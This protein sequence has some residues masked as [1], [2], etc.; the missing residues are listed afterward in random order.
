MPTVPAIC[1]RPLIFRPSNRTLHPAIRTLNTIGIDVFSR[2]SKSVL[3]LSCSIKAAKHDYTQ[4]WLSLCPNT[5]GSTPS[6][7]PMRLQGPAGQRD[8]TPERPSAAVQCSR[9]TVPSS[10]VAGI[11]TLGE[12]HDALHGGR[13]LWCGQL[14]RPHRVTRHDS[15]QAA[16]FL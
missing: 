14:C 1:R 8:H 10:G 5:P 11:R 12:Q 9:S 15:A 16:C 7:R 13:H 6:V 4:T 2:H 3:S